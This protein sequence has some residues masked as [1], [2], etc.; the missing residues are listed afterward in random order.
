MKQSNEENVCYV[1]FSYFPDLH[2]LRIFYILNP[3]G[4]S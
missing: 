4:D 1:Y 3:N 2:N